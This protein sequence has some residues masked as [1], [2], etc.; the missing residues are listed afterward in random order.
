MYN[1]NINMNDKKK[2]KK[3]HIFH[4]FYRFC[5]VVCIRICVLHTFLVLFGCIS[6]DMRIAYTLVL[7]SLVVFIYKLYKVL[8]MM[9]TKI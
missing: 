2:V 4:C 8:F 7:S 9:I 5:L 6:P 1:V 3:L